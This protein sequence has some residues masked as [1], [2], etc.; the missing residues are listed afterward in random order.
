MIIIIFFDVMTA[1]QV[2]PF[3]DPAQAKPKIV[4]EYTSTK[5]AVYLHSPRCPF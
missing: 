2:V 3:P 4:A 1:Q 5:L